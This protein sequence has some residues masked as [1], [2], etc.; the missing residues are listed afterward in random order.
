MSVAWLSELFPK[1]ISVGVYI[2][3]FM[4]APGLDFNKFRVS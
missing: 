4:P 1:N 2:A 3:A